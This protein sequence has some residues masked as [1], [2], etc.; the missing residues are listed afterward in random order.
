MQAEMRRNTEYVGLENAGLKN[1]DE[2]QF[3][4]IGRKIGGSLAKLIS[5]SVPGLW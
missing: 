4:S 2:I 3:I 5:V 1:A